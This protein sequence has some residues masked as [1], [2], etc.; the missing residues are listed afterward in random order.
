M[1]K[2]RQR[3][4]IQK[5]NELLDYYYDHDQHFESPTLDRVDELLEELK[6]IKNERSN[7]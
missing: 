1:S 3:E 5:I 7:A 6:E 2:D 4:I